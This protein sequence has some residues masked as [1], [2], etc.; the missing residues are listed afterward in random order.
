V[1]GCFQDGCWVLG[2]GYWKLT[3]IDSYIFF[4]FKKEIP[5]NK[6]P[7]RLN[8]KNKYVGHS[9]KTYILIFKIIPTRRI[10]NPK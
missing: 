4:H 10:N 5:I 1:V 3:D 6:M 7:K 8:K 9:L 2:F